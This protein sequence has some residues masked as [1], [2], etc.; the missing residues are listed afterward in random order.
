M[1]A[2]TRAYRIFF[3]VLALFV[4]ALVLAWP[5]LSSGAAIAAAA[6]LL[7]GSVLGFLKVREDQNQGV[8]QWPSLVNALPRSWQ[9]WMLG[10]DDKNRP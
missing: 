10:E 6:C 4:V 8:Q 5:A 3:M 7:I 2:K 1:Q 9:T